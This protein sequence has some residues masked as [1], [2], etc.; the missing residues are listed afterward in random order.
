MLETQRDGDH[1]MVLLV[2][3][4]DPDHIALASIGVDP[5]LAVRLFMTA[6]MELA[7][8]KSGAPP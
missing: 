6:G 5:A 7:R 2:D 3:R 1:V 8:K 4:D